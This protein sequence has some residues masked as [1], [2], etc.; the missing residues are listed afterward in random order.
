MDAILQSKAGLQADFCSVFGNPRRI[1]ILWILADQELSV[2]EIADNIQASIQNT[3][4]HLRLMK[5]RGILATRRSGS[6]V[7]YRLANSQ[8]LESCGL[9]ECKLRDNLIKE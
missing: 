9:L 3:S 8:M 7:F 2:G 1:L 6:T 4:Q 5:D